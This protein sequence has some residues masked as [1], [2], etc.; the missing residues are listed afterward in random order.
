MSRKRGDKIYYACFQCSSDSG[1]DL[2]REY[3]ATL[4][5]LVLDIHVDPAGLD[6]YYTL[7]VPMYSAPLDPTTWD[8]EKCR[9][10]QT[11][12]SRICSKYLP[13]VGSVVLLPSCDCQMIEKEN[14]S[15][16]LASSTLHHSLSECIGSLLRK[17]FCVIV[18]VQFWC[19]RLEL[20]S[21]N[22]PSEEEILIW[23]NDILLLNSLSLFDARIDF[24]FLV[25]LCRGSVK[26]ML[27]SLKAMRDMNCGIISSFEIFLICASIEMMKFSTVADDFMM[28]TLG[29]H[30]RFN[31]SKL[32]ST[33]V[34]DSLLVLLDKF[35]VE[36]EAIETLF[37][38]CDDLLLTSR[39]PSRSSSF[40]QCSFALNI[41]QSVFQ[42]RCPSFSVW[43]TSVINN[44]LNFIIDHKIDTLLRSLALKSLL[45]V[46]KDSGIWV[47]YFSGDH[48]SFSYSDA[49]HRLRDC[50]SW[51][52]KIMWC[53]VFE[54]Y[55]DSSS[56]I[57]C[58][59]DEINSIPRDED[60]TIDQGND[61]IQR[62]L[63]C[64][65]QEQL[66]L[67]IAAAK[68]YSLLIKNG[69]SCSTPILSSM[70]DNT[71]DEYV[72][73]ERNSVDL[74]SILF[75]I[76]CF[77]HVIIGKFD[78]L[79]T[80]VGYG[81]NHLELSA[82]W[83][84]N[85]IGKYILDVGLI[86]AIVSVL[87]SYSSHS[88]RRLS[89][90][91]QNM[92]TDMTCQ[93]LED[94]KSGDYTAIHENWIENIFIFQIR[95]LVLTFPSTFRQ[96][97]QSCSRGIQQDLIKFV[98][99]KLHKEIINREVIDLGRQ[100]T[101]D[102][103]LEVKGNCL[104]SELTAVYRHEEAEIALK[105]ILP[106]SYPLQNPEIVFTSKCG[107]T[108]DRLKKWKLS[109]LNTISLRDSSIFEAMLIWKAGIQKEFEGVEPCPICYSVLHAKSFTLPKL[110]CRTCKNAF[111]A[112]CLQT[113]FK[114]SGKS[115]CVICQQPFFI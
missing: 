75:N 41:F 43:K 100:S 21:T 88:L 31:I 49:I 64:D 90:S 36:I 76:G 115:K 93:S 86:D 53:N 22:S 3:L 109:M 55:F 95:K 71:T 24:K 58:Y 114:S 98:E 35:S 59:Q 27:Q 70:I 52:E 111:H 54:F 67:S 37:K 10:I 50:A 81:D 113:W 82:S 102:S 44:L 74:S 99:D 85:S 63:T 83:L 66:H 51:H 96:F 23:F 6:N 110:I 46:C 68:E 25:E 34:P 8:L 14:L 48:S 72:D 16:I 45:A 77:F 17:V 20:S 61:D 2:R 107:I 5:A 56:S 92:L 32:A 60:S 78:S 108:E 38:W 40:L 4:S 19:Q 18:D 103:E 80:K 87:L 30:I 9:E 101:K 65:E 15:A 26:L 84:R 79:V 69:S 73:N 106:S 104:T 11:E 13:S 97:F 91:V 89:G 33:C 39:I 7:R 12:D 105:I 94:I 112:R 1:N 62:F 29:N 42:S 47:V 57:L 28:E